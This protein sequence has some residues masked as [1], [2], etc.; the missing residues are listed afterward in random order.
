MT[1]DGALHV[2]VTGAGG[3]VGSALVARLQA[4]PGIVCTALYRH[5]APP[6]SGPPGRA[7][8]V[9]DLQA[10]GDLSGPLAGVDV[11]VHAAARA[12]IMTDTAAS[13]LAAFRA[14]NVDAT[15][16]LAGEAAKAGVRRFVFVSSIKVNGERTLPRQAL[17][18]RRPA[19]AGRPLR[20]LQARGR[21]GACRASRRRPAWRS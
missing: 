1:G 21:A 2:A 6:P 20:R 4:E 11:V 10:A 3:F 8:A 19:C 5:Q 9:G 7:I 14:A 16:H 18:R 13:P 17:P 12:H 15:L